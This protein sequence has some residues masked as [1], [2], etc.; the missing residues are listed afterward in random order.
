[1]AYNEDK[2]K[3]SARMAGRDEKGRN[4][5]QVLEKTITDFRNKNPGT[6][7]EVGGHHFA[8]G[9]LVE[10]E[11]EEEFLELLKQNLEI[12]ILKI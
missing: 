7:A 5:K 8:A 1:M 6:K 11:K 4:L 9:C 10:K 2:I 3:I 12:E